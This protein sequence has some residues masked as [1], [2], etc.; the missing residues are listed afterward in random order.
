MRTVKQGVKQ[1]RYIK[2]LE[3]INTLNK[4][5]RQGHRGYFDCG[6]LGILFVWWH[7]QW[8]W[9]WIELS[10]EFKEDIKPNN[11]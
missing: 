2:V 1:D 10:T 3:I 9:E 6:E 4:T 7:R 8:E 11:P 5:H